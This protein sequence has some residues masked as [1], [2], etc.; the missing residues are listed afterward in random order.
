MD[1]VCRR[2]VSACGTV[3]YVWLKESR[4]R[5]P[6]V[7]SAIFS[8]K[9]WKCK[10]PRQIRANRPFKLLE[11]GTF[12]IHIGEFILWLSDKVHEIWALDHSY[13]HDLKGAKK[14]SI[15]TFTV[16]S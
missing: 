2:S 11:L 5:L 3:S 14:A 15:P 8:L 1:Y 10:F 12:P 16:P 6:Y 7:A 13:E 4:R 9:I